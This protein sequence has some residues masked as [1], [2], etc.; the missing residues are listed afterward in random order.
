MCLDN[1]IHVHVVQH[2][3]SW[4]WRVQ[5]PKWNFMW[6]VG[7]SFVTGVGVVFCTFSPWLKFCP[8]ISFPQQVFPPGGAVQQ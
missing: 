5:D 3:R 6:Y 7:V 2:D 1:K 4:N 8:K